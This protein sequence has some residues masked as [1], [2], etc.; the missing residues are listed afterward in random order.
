M[1]S[2]VLLLLLAA[3]T[4]ARLRLGSAEGDP[5]PVSLVD[6]VRNSPISSVDDLKLLLQQETNA[7]EE[8]E[9]EHDIPSNHTHARYARSLVEAPMAQQAAC[10]VRTEVMEVTRSM[11]DRRNANFILWPPCVEVQ[12]CSGCCNTRVLQCVPMVTSSRYLQV[13]KI[14]Y[15]N[16]KPHYDK[17]IISVEDHVTCRCQTSTPPSSS[18]SL[19]VPRTSI[20][21]NPNPP[22]PQQPPPSSHILRPVHPSPPKTQTSK[23]DLHRHDDL[24]HNQQHFRPEERDSVA[25]Q[26][27]QGSYTQ[28]VHWTQPRAHQTPTHVQQPTVGVHPPVH[29]WPSEARAEH[30]IMGSTPPVGQGSGYDGSKEESGVHVANG[31]G[32]EH[33][34]DHMQ[35]QQQLLQHQQRQQQHQYHQQPHYPTQ[36][37]P[38]GAAAAAPHDQELRTQYRLDAPQSDSAS[39]PASPTEPPTIDPN[40]TPPL[41]TKQRDSVTTLKTPE[42][43]NP[44][45]TET[46]TASQK[47]GNEREESGSA[48]SGSG[49]E[50]A[51]QGTEKDSKVTGGYGHLTEEE[52]RRLTLE[53][54][55]R[56]LDRETHLHPH[57]P[58]QRPK[59]TAFKTALPTASSLLTSARQAPFRPASPRRRRRKH[60]K[61]ISKSAI[62]AMIM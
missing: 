17:A 24:K 11:L 34:P 51:N 26:W 48:N 41:T 31:G 42:V 39:P 4:A 43:T 29:G 12:R 53:T 21:S 27:Q 13:Y 58:Q 62:R 36:Y 60:R 3:L 45:Q 9:D 55:Q 37:N 1:R 47:E 40:P 44:K 22:P 20:L 52:R 16:R 35:R 8:E 7:I 49:A 6:Q 10:K 15:I 25:R 14:Q 54:I 56:E 38:G 59:P 2:W 30:S 50:L 23:A 32:E 57:T 33:H 5:L 61:R 28:L 19:P 46:A 18:S